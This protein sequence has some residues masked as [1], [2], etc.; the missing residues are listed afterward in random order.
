M[1]PAPKTTMFI[2]PALALCPSHL[3]RAQHTADKL[4]P[5][6]DELRGAHGALTGQLHLVQQQPTA[7]RQNDNPVGDARYQGLIEKLTVE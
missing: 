5:T 4:R 1:A 2:A 3:R 6:T 7:P